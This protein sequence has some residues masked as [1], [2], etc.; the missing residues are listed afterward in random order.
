MTEAEQRQWL[1]VDSSL[2][3]LKKLRHSFTSIEQERTCLEEAIHQ[4]EMI[5]ELLEEKC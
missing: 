1:E 2:R 4:L 3:I 5:K